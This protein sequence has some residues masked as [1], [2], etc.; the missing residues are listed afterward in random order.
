MRLD[1]GRRTG[2]VMARAL[3]DVGVERAL[4]QEV[5]ATQLA[6][7]F[8]EYPNEFGAD[9]SPLLLGIDHPLQSIQKPGT[10]VDGDQA[11]CNGAAEDLLEVT[12]F[13]LAEQTVVDEDTG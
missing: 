1:L 12:C 4:G 11:R 2:R 13:V 3:D 6:R 5:Y 8:L 9:G 10:G 7:L